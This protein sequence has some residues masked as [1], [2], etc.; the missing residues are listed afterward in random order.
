MPC[1]FQLGRTYFPVL[2]FFVKLIQA[3][4]SHALVLWTARLDLLKIANPLAEPLR[5]SYFPLFHKSAC[6][7]CTIGTMD[8]NE[9]NGRERGTKK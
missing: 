6:R 7:S 5:L 4:E 9:N 3:E 8:K 2:P 1:K